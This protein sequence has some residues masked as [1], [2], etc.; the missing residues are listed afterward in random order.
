MGML[1]I[2]RVEYFKNIPGTLSNKG[3]G[4]LCVTVWADL[5]TIQELVCVGSRSLCCM[6]PYCR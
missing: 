1:L 6:I 3:E 5:G 4:L 2:E